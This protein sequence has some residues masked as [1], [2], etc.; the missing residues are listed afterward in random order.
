MRAVVYGVGAAGAR[1]ARQLAS[2]NELKS[3]RLID[4]RKEVL[5]E[6][7]ESIGS[8]A[9]AADIDSIRLDTRLE[10]FAEVCTDA[11]V[12]FLTAYDDHFDL[13]RV[14][15]GCNA[16]V[17]ST[18]DDIRIV[19]ELLSMDG[20]ARSANRAVIAGAGFSP[21][22]TCVLAAHG[23]KWLDSVDEVHVAKMGTGGPSCARQH[24]KALRGDALDWYNRQWVR[25]RGGS[26]RELCWFPDPVGG[27]D[28]YQAAVPDPALLLEAFPD[29][30]RASTRVAA[31]RRDRSTKWLPM[32]RRPHPEG[33][34]GAVRTEV[35][36]WSGAIRSTVI[37][38]AIHRPAAAAATV[39][40][41]AGEWAHRDRLTRAGASGL[42]ELVGD[43]TSFLG[44]LSVRGVTA[45]R[46]EGS[47]SETA[48]RP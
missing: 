30:V 31:T 36:G 21:G 43:T 42:A 39:A 18:S 17:V 4:D 12:V 26:G 33:L 34:V 11:D 29:L 2:N 25:R 8:P 16:H 28:C 15:L 45:A 41:L 10:R 13:A 22:L 27:R 9:A 5:D 7:V 37:L 20:D 35:R 24:H 6:V 46:F 19:E 38:G 3:L 1:I 47:G 40:A 44:E 32:M 23:A 48:D 14:A